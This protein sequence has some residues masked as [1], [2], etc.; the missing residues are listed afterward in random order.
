MDLGQH[1]GR[2]LASRS[3]SPTINPVRRALLAILC[4]APLAPAAAE[5]S[6]PVEERVALREL[7]SRQAHGSSG[8]VVPLPLP[9]G[10][11]TSAEPAVAAATIARGGRP[12]RV[13]VGARAHADVPALAAKLRR[14]G[15]EPEV[16][17]TIGVLAVRAPS[18][19]GARRGAGP[20][21]S[22]R[23]R[24]ARSDPEGDGRSLRHGRP[25]H[26]RQVHLVLRGRARGRGTRRRRRGLAAL[27]RRDR[28]RPRRGPPRVRRRGG[29]R[30]PSTPVRETPT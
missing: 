1:Q 13:L 16:F 15:A 8:T 14:L 27:G 20:R 12:A 23:L 4:A 28:H 22:G 7:L 9:S 25:C 29:S 5:A 19:S 10:V 2:R 30:A 24:R 3:G 21:S 17:D 18:A 6:A 11:S 26:R